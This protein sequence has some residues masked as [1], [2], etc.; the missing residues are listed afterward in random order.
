MNSMMRGC[1]YS[2][3]TI[4]TKSTIHHFV[5]AVVKVNEFCKSQVWFN[6]NE[7][8]HSVHSNN[9]TN[10]CGL[11]YCGSIECKSCRY[12]DRDENGVKNIY[13]VSNDA[14]PDI[15]SRIVGWKNS[16]RL[17]HY[18]DQFCDDNKSNKK[19]RHESIA[20]DDVLDSDMETSV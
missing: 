6:C 3:P 14:V 1:K 4:R 15:F 12:K 10:I 7:R 17:V 5:S 11:L 16:K 2:A 9:G 20:Q 19:P 13:K 8:T 18:L